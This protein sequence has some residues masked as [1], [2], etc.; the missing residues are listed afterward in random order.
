M[1]NSNHRASSSS[2]QPP[3]GDTGYHSVDPHFTTHHSSTPYHH[4][5]QHTFSATIGLRDHTFN[6][7]P[8]ESKTLPLKREKKIKTGIHRPKSG[9]IVPSSLSNFPAPYTTG[10]PHEQMNGSMSLSRD[11]NFTSGHVSE[12]TNRMGLHRPRSAAADTLSG[13]SFRSQSSAGS[14]YSPRRRIA[15]IRENAIKN[16]GY[17][18]V[19][20][21]HPS[22]TTTYTSAMLGA[23]IKSL[24]DSSHFIP[25]G[26]VAPPTNRDNLHMSM[27]KIT[28][29]NFGIYGEDD[30]DIDDS[31]YQPTLISE[32]ALTR[33]MQRLG[34]T[35]RSK[36]QM[37]ILKKTG[38][39]SPSQHQINLSLAKSLTEE[40]LRASVSNIMTSDGSRSERER[41]KSVMDL[42]PQNEKLFAKPPRPKSAI[43]S[44][45]LK[46]PERKENVWDESTLDA[47][48]LN[49]STVSTMSKKELKKRK[50][51]R[52]K[53]LG[54]GDTEGKEKRRGI[55][56]SLKNI[57]FKKRSVYIYEHTWYK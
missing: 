51:L 36:S 38:I 28:T 50:K 12:A 35:P 8:Y 25:P 6:A 54:G 30:D 29:E 45:P 44:S 56:D 32:E 10:I 26:P 22:T 1:Y 16:G 2:L 7:M 31:M 46:R 52:D 34:I 4:P 19:H 11:E 15:E 5:S 39:D 37:D 49:Q 21:H 48:M 14:G 9:E 24:P 18:P 13:E 27:P 41:P 20:V 47:S 17:S 55:K 53:L 3:G 42:G 40:S 43:F 33:K 57:F 23:S